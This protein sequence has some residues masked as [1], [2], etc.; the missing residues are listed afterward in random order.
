MYLCDAFYDNKLHMIKVLMQ[1]FRHLL[2]KACDGPSQDQ[3]EVDS[4]DDLPWEDILIEGTD[5]WDE[6]D[7]V[8]WENVETDQI[9]H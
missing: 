8:G 2:N 9:A 3:M 4:F 7:D 1:L 6:D 5:V